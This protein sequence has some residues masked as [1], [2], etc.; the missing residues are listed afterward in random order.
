MRAGYK[1]F[2]IYGGGGG[3]GWGGG[4]HYRTSSVGGEKRDTLAGGR[5]SEE[6]YVKR[7]LKVSEFVVGNTAV[8]EKVKSPH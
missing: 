2:D 7:E 6:N 5:K 8:R 1:W 4:V 3:G